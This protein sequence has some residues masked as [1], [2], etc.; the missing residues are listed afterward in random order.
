MKAST[1]LEVATA[2][3]NDE[4]GE[5]KRKAWEKNVEKKGGKSTLEVKEEAWWKVVKREDGRKKCWWALC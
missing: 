3:A 5:G 1:F 4:I 2:M